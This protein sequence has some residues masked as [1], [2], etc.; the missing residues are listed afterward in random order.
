MGARRP[1][2]IEMQHMDLWFDLAIRGE[3]N[4]EEEALARFQRTEGAEPDLGPDDRGHD[5]PASPSEFF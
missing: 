4:L 5:E 3:T 2:V 1:E